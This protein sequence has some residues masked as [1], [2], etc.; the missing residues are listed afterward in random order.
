LA[1]RSIRCRALV[2][3]VLVDRVLGRSGFHG[4]LA[5][6]LA[7]A[8]WLASSGISDVLLAYPTV[9]RNALAVLVRNDQLR[10]SIM[11]MVDSVK[12]CEI[13]TSAAAGR[14]I[15][16]CIDIDASLRIGPLHL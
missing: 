5:Y 6:S 15:K 12:H 9:N 8:I 11:V 16:V 14:S 1:T 13:I 7:E 3:R 10:E 2:E 4:V